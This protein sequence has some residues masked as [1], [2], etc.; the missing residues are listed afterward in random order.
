[1]ADMM[2]WYVQLDKKNNTISAEQG[3]EALSKFRDKYQRNPTTIFVNP[4]QKVESIDG[5]S[6]KEDTR[7]LT[8]HML[9]AEKESDIT[10]ERK[11]VVYQ[12]RSDNEGIN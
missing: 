12:D 5:I 9:I 2:L 4:K 3:K 8:S 1:M 7:V 11:G 10:P 6:I